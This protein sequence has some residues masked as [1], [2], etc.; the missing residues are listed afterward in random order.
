MRP[1]AFTIYRFP[2]CVK[3][4]LA[5]CLALMG[6]FGLIVLWCAYSLP[7][8]IPE[9]ENAFIRPPPLPPRPGTSSSSATMTRPGSS[10]VARRVRFRTTR[11]TSADNS[12]ELLLSSRDDEEEVTDDNRLGHTCSK[13]KS[14]RR[15]H[16]GSGGHRNPGFEINK[17]W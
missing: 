16:S 13:S 15:R 17:R 9:Q 5:C 14:R 10:L 4:H 3:A 8:S 6:V 12:H 1:F 2:F 11:S 7:Y